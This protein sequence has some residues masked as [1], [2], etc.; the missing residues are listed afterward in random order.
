MLE[1]TPESI[2]QILKEFPKM[3]NAYMEMKARVLKAGS[4]NEFKNLLCC[5]V[6]GEG[7]SVGD[8]RPG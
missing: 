4:L 6:R 8:L 5:E 1:I 2:R 7:G 3:L